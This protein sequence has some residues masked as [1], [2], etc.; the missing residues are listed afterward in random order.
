LEQRRLTSRTLEIFTAIRLAVGTLLLDRKRNCCF[1]R[2]ATTNR[3]AAIFIFQQ[4]GAVLAV[5]V[6]VI[7]VGQICFRKKN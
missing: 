1:V 3:R 7:V 6:V 5:V 2:P 4:K